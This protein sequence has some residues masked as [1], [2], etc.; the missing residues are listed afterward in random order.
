MERAWVTDYLTSAEH[1]ILD[2]LVKIT[3]LGKDE[4]A[5]RSN[6]KSKVGIMGFYMSNAIL[7]LW[8]F[9]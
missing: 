1:K 8:F 3:F 5:V 9:H 4:T 6:I 7:G 2:W